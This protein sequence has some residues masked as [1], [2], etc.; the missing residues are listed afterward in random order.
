MHRGTHY[1][2]VPGPN[3]GRRDSLPQ[4]DKNVIGPIYFDSTVS[5]NDGNRVTRSNT[6]KSPT[7]DEM[8]VL[9][10]QIFE[11]QERIKQ[12]YQAITKIIEQAEAI[13]AIAEPASEIARNLQI[14]NQQF[15]DFVEQLPDFSLISRQVSITQQVLRNIQSIIRP[16]LFD[17]LK[18]VSDKYLEIEKSGFEYKWLKSVSCSFFLHIYAEYEKGGNDKATEYLMK[19]LQEGSSIE[20]LKTNLEHFSYYKQRKII[21]D[22]ALDA[23]KEGKYALSTPTLMTQIAGVFIQ[24]G[25]DLGKWGTEDWPIEVTAVKKKIEGIDDSFKDYYGRFMGTNSIRAGVIHGVNIDYAFD[26]KLSAKVIWILFEALHVVEEIKN[27][28]QKHPLKAI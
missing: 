11:W 21:I 16:E 6:M 24:L 19:A 4:T 8:P 27:D 10:T 3:P 26:D 15:S 22:Q 2:D 18:R 9:A 12:Q 28:Q 17:S 25:I 13:T 14:V 20:K 1:C 5:R 23:H 7:L